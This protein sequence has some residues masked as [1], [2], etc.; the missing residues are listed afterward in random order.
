MYPHAR[1]HVSTCM[2]LYIYVHV[3]VYPHAQ[4]HVCIN[5]V[6][7]PHACGCLSMS[8]F[9]Y[10]LWATEQNL[11]QHCGPLHRILLSAM[12][13]GTESLTTTQNHSKFIEKFATTYKGTV[14]QKVYIYKLHYPRLIPSKLEI[15]PS[16]E[17]KLILRCGPLRRMIF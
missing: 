16:L 8:E 2:Q 12:G 7:C 10:A 9:R 13:H 5:V 11:A 6:N 17:K 14:K 1:G 15:L 3:A 4:G